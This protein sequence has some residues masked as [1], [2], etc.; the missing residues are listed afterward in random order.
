MIGY[1]PPYKESCCEEE[2]STGYK[3]HQDLEEGQRLYQQL[4]DENNYLREQVRLKNSQGPQR[5]QQIT[6]IHR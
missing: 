3:L 4:L 2:Y 5:V 1:T 6:Q